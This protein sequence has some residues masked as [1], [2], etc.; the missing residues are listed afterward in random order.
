MT[1]SK[2]GPDEDFPEDLTKLDTDDVENLNSKVERQ[3]DHEYVKEG[4]LHPETAFRDH[5]L[6]SELDARDEA[7]DSGS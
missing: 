2:L 6:D 5:E 7:E 4:D 1:D 3:V